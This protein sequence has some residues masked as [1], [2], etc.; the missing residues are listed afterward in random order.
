MLRLAR[1]I[2]SANGSIAVTW[3]VLSMYRHVRCARHRSRSRARPSPRDRPGRT[4]LR[5]DDLAH[6]AGSTSDLPSQAVEATIGGWC[7][8]CIAG[9]PHP[10]GWR[11]GMHHRP[12]SARA[13]LSAFFWTPV[14]ALALGHVTLST[15]RLRRPFRWASPATASGLVS[16]EAARPIRAVFHRVSHMPLIH[17][18]HRAGTLKMSPN[19]RR[20][21][22][23]SKTNVLC[24]HRTP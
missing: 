14:G 5:S 11:R 10:V 6:R 16:S 19:C 21:T 24:L 2:D 1:S 23:M 12:G 22:W 13:D 9:L 7:A 8:I 15:T 4:A 3:A 17:E 18:F 20:Q